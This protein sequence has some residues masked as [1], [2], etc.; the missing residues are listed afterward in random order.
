MSSFP[1]LLPTLCG[2]REGLHL[3]CVVVAFAVDLAALVF[4]TQGSL[5]A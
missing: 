5:V 1:C 4:H 2:G 3:L